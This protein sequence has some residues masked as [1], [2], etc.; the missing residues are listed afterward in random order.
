[1]R[2]FGQKSNFADHISIYENPSLTEIAL[3]WRYFRK[4]FTT[5]VHHEV[6]SC[7]HFPISVNGGK[8]V[9]KWSEKVRIWVEITNFDFFDVRGSFWNNLSPD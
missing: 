6:D 7:S 4:T 1:M 8:N 9:Q 5:K 3:Y 2:E